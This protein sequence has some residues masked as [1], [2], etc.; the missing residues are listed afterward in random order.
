MR[1]CRYIRDLLESTVT[2]FCRLLVV[3]VVRVRVE[4]CAGRA[5]P[6]KRHR[7][8]ARRLKRWRGA[9]RTTRSTLDD[10]HVSDNTNVHCRLSKRSAVRQIH[11]LLSLPT[12][13]RNLLNAR[14]VHFFSAT[15]C[16]QRTTVR[17]V[18]RRRVQHRDLVL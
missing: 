1:S 10:H 4:P 16:T 8:G 7:P 3:V 6:S 11:F 9:S 5:A 13:L 14:V 18:I 15:F 17:V 2:F 12:R